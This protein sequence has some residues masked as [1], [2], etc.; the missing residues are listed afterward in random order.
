MVGRVYGGIT[1]ISDLITNIISVAGNAWYGVGAPFPIGVW[2]PIANA[3][4][5]THFS[6]GDDPSQIAADLASGYGAALYFDAF[7]AF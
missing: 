3:A 2:D 5:L 4:P 7:G 6:I 1:T